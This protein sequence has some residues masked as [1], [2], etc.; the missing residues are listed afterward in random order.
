M[1]KQELMLWCRYYIN[2]YG[3]YRCVSQE[4]YK[5][6][7]DR[8]IAKADWIMNILVLVFTIFL[9]VLFLNSLRKDME[10]IKKENEE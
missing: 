4:I 2:E 5:D 8:K 10:K 3:N 1:E 9:V 6:S 7:I